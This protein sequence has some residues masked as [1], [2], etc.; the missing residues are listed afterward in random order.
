MANAA[1]IDEMC[2][3]LS[4]AFSRR[5]PPALAMGITAAEFE[6]MVRLYCDAAANDG[7]TVIARSSDTGKLAGALLTEDAATPQP[8]G[9]DRLS[10]KFHPVFEILGELYEGIEPAAKNERLHLFLLGV[11]ESFAGRGIAKQLVRECMWNGHRRG[12]CTAVA[13][14]TN[15]ISQSVFRKLG[16]SDRASRSYKD[17]RYHG[18]AVF[19][20]IAESGGPILM[21]K[22]IEPAT[23]KR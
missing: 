6:A 9:I 7:L 16:F 20:S 2:H 12:Y 13:E 23:A 18:Q 10:S 1:D 11:D 5:D 22:P 21:D 19:A 4:E 8:D 14:A 17:F 3:L 15:P